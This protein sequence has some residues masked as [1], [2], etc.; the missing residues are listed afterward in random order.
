MNNFEEQYIDLRLQLEKTKAEL[1]ETQSM[2]KQYQDTPPT[3]S[4]SSQWWGNS[5]EITCPWVSE[6][7]LQS[8]FINKAETT[9][10]HLR[11]WCR[12]F[13]YEHLKLEGVLT[14][15]FR[16]EVYLNSTWN[17]NSAVMFSLQGTTESIYSRLGTELEG[18]IDKN[19]GVPLILTSWFYVGR[20]C[21][22]RMP[23]AVVR[24]D[25][26]ATAPIGLSLSKHISQALVAQSTTSFESECHFTNVDNTESRFLMTTSPD[27]GR[28]MYRYSTEHLYGNLDQEDSHELFVSID[29]WWW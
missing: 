3:L 28:H 4:L 13:V 19:S 6:N 2:L 22:T 21:L 7:N 15:V 10:A 14:F 20:A 8:I 9:P 12:A 29:D 5:F 18:I 27:S 24:A 26:T 16:F 25:A 17:N 1:E 11:S 23:L